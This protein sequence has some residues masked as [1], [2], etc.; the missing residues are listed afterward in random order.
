[1]SYRILVLPQF[2]TMTPRLLEKVAKLVA[3]GATVMGM[4]PR[5]SPSLTGYP[6]CDEQV[7]QL[8]GIL[9]GTGAPA[10]WRNVG[11]GYVIY[12]NMTAAEEA[13]TDLPA[14]KSD[15]GSLASARLKF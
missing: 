5:K 11:K 3:D 7:R 6:Q 8:A 10:S 9:W 14:H 13:G 1:M 4:P 15:E 2:D 12:C